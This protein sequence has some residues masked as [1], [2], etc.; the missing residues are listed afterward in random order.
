MGIST[1]SQNGLGRKRPQSPSQHRRDAGGTSNE[2][3][4]SCPC[5]VTQSLSQALG[6][7]GGSGT[8]LWALTLLG[9]DLGQEV[10]QERQGFAVVL[11]LHLDQLRGHGTGVTAPPGTGTAGGRVALTV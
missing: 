11:G 4:L 2:R 7:T 1:E 3:V 10:L 6:V 5:G 9:F 8:E